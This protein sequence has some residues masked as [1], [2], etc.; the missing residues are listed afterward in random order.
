MNRRVLLSATVVATLV[1]IAFSTTTDANPN[2]TTGTL[3]SVESGWGGEGIYLVVTPAIS[4]AC[5]GKV[6]MPT[7]ATQYKENLALAMLALAQGMQV[8]I[9]YSATC[10]ANGFADFVSLS[11]GPAS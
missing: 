7:T 8:T 11:I 1:A 2:A 3:V 4:P 9:F 6:Y 5:N 10:D